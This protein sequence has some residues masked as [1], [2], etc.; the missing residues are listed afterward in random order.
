MIVTPSAD[1]VYDGHDAIPAVPTNA[2]ATK[3]G[4]TIKRVVTTG[5]EPNVVYVS[6]ATFT[7][8]GFVPGE[9]A[10]CIN[11]LATVGTTSEAPALA[12]KKNSD[13]SAHVKANGSYDIKFSTTNINK[14][15]V[16]NE[17]VS[18]KIIYMNNAF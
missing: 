17:S 8:Q 3:A 5:E 9:D 2:V 11:V 18:F 6:T 14:C 7:F 16:K 12:W 4:Q 13:K 15:Y 10:T 1:K